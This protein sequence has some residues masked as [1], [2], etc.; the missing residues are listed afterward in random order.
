MKNIFPLITTILEEKSWRIQYAL[1][2]NFEN[3]ILSVQTNNK[4]SLMDFYLSCMQSPEEEVVII[5]FKILKNI[6]NHLEPE[7]II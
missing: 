7:F 2:E 1:L 5:A 4:K 3:I 6:S